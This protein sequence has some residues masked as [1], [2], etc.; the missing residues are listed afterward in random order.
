MKNTMKK[1]LLSFNIFLGTMLVLAQ[2]VPPPP[3]NP[4]SGDIGAPATPIDN[5]LFV[6]AILAFMIIYYYKTKH[7]KIRL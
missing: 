4:E 5:Y 2:S 3:P 1:I 6:L 7:K